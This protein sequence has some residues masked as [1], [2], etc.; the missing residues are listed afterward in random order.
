MRILAP[1]LFIVLLTCI[2]VQ[3]KFIA[4]VQVSAN[5]LNISGSGEG[6]GDDSS[7]R[8]MLL[9][10]LRSDGDNVEKRY[11]V[12]LGWDSTLLMLYTM[13][14]LTADLPK[15]TVDEWLDS[16]GTKTTT[17]SDSA[18]TLTRRDQIKNTINLSLGARIGLKLGPVVL[19]Y[20]EFGVYGG[21]FKHVIDQPKDPDDIGIKDGISYKI[22]MYYGFGASLGASKFMATAGFKHYLSRKITDEIKTNIMKRDSRSIVNTIKDVK[23]GNF[24]GFVTIA[25]R[26]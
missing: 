2:P 25:I 12:V 9:S 4:G 10:M 17:T 16:T 21:R 6:L 14:A 18:T 26:V 7:K 24:A 1:Y 23:Y 11:G 15:S 13:V 8:K 19:P 20:F 5:R 22:N 3:A